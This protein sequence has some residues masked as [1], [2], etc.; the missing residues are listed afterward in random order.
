MT[1]ANEFDLLA[2]LVGYPGEEYPE[3]RSALP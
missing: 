1:G 2:S 3:Q